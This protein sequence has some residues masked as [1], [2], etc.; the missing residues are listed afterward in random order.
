MDA[1][2]QRVD[3]ILA[4]LELED[5]KAAASAK[6]YCCNILKGHN[7]LSD[8]CLDLIIMAFYDG[9]RSKS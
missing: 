1:I 5:I 7:G 8:V 3:K 4:D 9:Y 2:N 6:K